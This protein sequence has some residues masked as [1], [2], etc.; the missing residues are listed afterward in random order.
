M[1]DS[2]ELSELRRQ[3]RR[4]VRK[5]DRKKARRLSRQLR[6]QE[7]EE[8]LERARNAWGSMARRSQ[9]K[10]TNERGYGLEHKRL[11]QKVAREVAAGLA[12]CARCGYLIQPDEPW[13]LGHDDHDRS[14]WI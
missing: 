11:R 12:T 9:R 10:K 6:A 2:S 4:A 14:V 13:D 8:R 7:E 3:I 1:A 5:G